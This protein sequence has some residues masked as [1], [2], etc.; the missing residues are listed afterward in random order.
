MLSMASF[1]IAHFCLFSGMQ[2][3]LWTETVRT[4][5]QM[6]GMIFPRVLALA[7]R[8]W[9]KASWE[10]VTE[11]KNRDEMMEDDWVKFAN[12][13]GYRELNRL[14]KMKVPYRVPLPGVR[15]EVDL[16]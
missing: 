9:H 8:A 7:E 15:S 16:I 5:D 6:Y 11:Q 12:S 2:G 14:D 4:A 3:H 1:C 10:D 13:L